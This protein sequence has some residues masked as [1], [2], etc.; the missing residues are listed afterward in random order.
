M[1]IV[2]RS[3]RDVFRKKARTLGVILI[4]GLTLGVFL[5]LSIVDANVAASAQQLAEGIDTIVTVRPAGSFGFFSSETIDESV[6]PLVEASPHVVGVQKLIL[7]REGGGQQPGG[8]PGG[9]GG[10]RQGALVEGLD[11][12]EDLVIFGGGTILLTSGRSLNADDADARVAL[13]G[14]SY[15]ETQGVGLGDDVVV[16][17]TSFTVVGLF[18]SGTVF[19]DNAILIPFE[20]ARSALGLAGPHLLYVEVDTVGNVDATVAD[21]GDSLGTEFDVVPLS[22]TQGAFLQSALDAIRASSQLGASISLGTGLAVMVFTMVL[23]TRERVREMGLL[24]ALGFRNGKIVSQFFLESLMLAGLGFL[25]GLVVA[26]VG[27]PTLANLLARGA[28]PAGGLVGSFL[29]VEFALDP[30]VVVFALLATALMG[31]VG[32]LY[33]IVKALRMS[34][35]EALRD[36]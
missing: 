24:K 20:A 14:V 19:G 22:T 6:L 29:A 26:I 9:R 18:T 12:S 33:P 3:L 7:F 1:S 10:P 13:V 4:V 34:P 28:S 36:E 11:P 16:N 21:L 23:V 27:G 17:G 32:S 15:G 8:G 25:V 35:A 31:V 5:T 2:S 30:T